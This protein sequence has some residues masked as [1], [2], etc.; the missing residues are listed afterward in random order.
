MDRW[1]SKEIDKMGKIQN[2][3]F[4]IFGFCIEIKTFTFSNF[5]CQLCLP[6]H[7]Q[8]VKLINLNFKL[9]NK[10]KYINKWQPQNLDLLFFIANRKWLSNYCNFTYFFGTLKALQIAKLWEIIRAYWIF[11]HFGKEYA[12]SQS[13]AKNMCQF[14]QFVF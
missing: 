14:W 9:S 5:L 4:Y 12:F 8:N 6:I 11:E 2:I 10:Q 1:I 13:Q 7:D 3:S